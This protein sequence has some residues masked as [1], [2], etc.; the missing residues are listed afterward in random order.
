MADREVNDIKA[1]AKAANFFFLNS[2][3]VADI[4][5]EEGR[6][7]KIDENGNVVDFAINEK[8]AAGAERVQGGS[9]ND[10]RGTAVY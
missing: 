9:E 10:Q 4:G 5:A 2:R 1:M 6:A 8:C 7:V 3:T